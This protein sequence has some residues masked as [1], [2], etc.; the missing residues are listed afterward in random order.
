MTAHYDRLI[1]ILLDLHKRALALA[2]ANRIHIDA[3]APDYRGSAENLLH[4][5]A[6]RQVDLRDLQESLSTLGLSSL[7]RAEAHALHTLEAV[8]FAL[9]KLAGKPPAFAAQSPL[10]YEAGNRLLEA[11]TR[12]LFGMAAGKRDV[13]IMVTMPSE[14]ADNPDLVR[15]LLASG[16]DVMRINCAHDDANAWARMIGHLREAQRE[17]G[18]SCKVY[19]DLAG[20][21]LRTGLIAP[22]AHVLKLR[23]TRDARGVVQAKARAV[24]APMSEGL[25]IIAEGDAPAIPISDALVKAARRGD[26]FTLID[27]R[28]KTRTLTVT[29]KRA[30]GACVEF[31]KTIYFESRA[32]ITLARKGKKVAKGQVGEL[33]ARIEPIMLRKGDTLILTNDD[34]PGRPATLDAKGEV[35]APARISCSLDGAF[36]Q[37]CA[38]ESL[39][40]DDGRIGGVVQQ[41]DGRQMTVRITQAEAGGAKLQAEKG[42][43]LPDSTLRMPAL[44]A[45][46]LDDLAFMAPRVDIIGMSFVREPD[47]VLALIEQYDRL[48]AHQIGTVLKI[49]NKHAFNNLPRLLLA[50]MQRPPVGV[51]VARGD[52]AVEVGFERLAEVQEQILWLCEAAHVPVI[53]ATQVLE[54]MAKRGAPSRAEVSDAVMSGRAECVMLNKGPYIL[55]TVRFLNGV[56][57]RMNAHQFKKRSRLRPLSVSRFATT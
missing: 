9:H 25:P 56:L 13:R 54:S 17:L 40:L 46:D 3:V 6:L 21:K 37:V 57:E 18:R 47:D 15:N 34:A 43:N 49:E 27:A 32:E 5:L 29:E 30:G 4:Y 31:G 12:Q 42:I 16:M 28:G 19:A 36:D 22:A 51:M 23:P 33:P 55:D 44:T 11:H 53:W 38:G 1:G 48:N 41:N 8:L 20:P 35:T 45:K 50:S 24:L 14:A 7:G 2:D 52:L 26:A 39:W 10:S